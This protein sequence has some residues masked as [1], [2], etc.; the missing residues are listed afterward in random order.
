[1]NKYIINYYKN[2]QDKIIETPGFFEINYDLINKDWNNKLNKSI[3]SKAKYVIFES[4]PKQIN[5]TYGE[6]F[7][8]SIYLALNSLFAFLRIQAKIHFL[9]YL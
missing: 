1:M 6:H 7:E 5:K 9:N 3:Y 4:H 8:G 2:V